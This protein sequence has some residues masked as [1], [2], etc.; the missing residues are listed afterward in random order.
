MITNVVLSDV[1]KV[2]VKC[3]QHQVGLIQ[4]LLWQI[5]SSLLRRFKQILFFY[6]VDQFIR[7]TGFRKLS[8]CEQKHVGYVCLYEQLQ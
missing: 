4:Y 6:F 3:F 5:Q 1:N 2:F 7:R 8:V